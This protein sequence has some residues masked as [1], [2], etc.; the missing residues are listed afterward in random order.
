M[1]YSEKYQMSQQSKRTPVQQA[2][3]NQEDSK[4]T[5]IVGVGAVQSLG[6]EVRIR[7]I[8]STASQSKETIKYEKISP[9]RIWALPNSGP[10]GFAPIRSKARKLRGQGDSGGRAKEVGQVVR[11]H[12]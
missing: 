7:K 8:Q 2:G 6:R 11:V 3:R 5:S 10:L 12:D 4:I 1:V 9:R